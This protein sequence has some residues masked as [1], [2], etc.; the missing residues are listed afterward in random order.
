MRLL[1]TSLQR[2]GWIG[3]QTAAA[4]GEMIA[5]SARLEVAADKF[6]GIEPIIV[7]SDGTRPVVVIRTD[8]PSGDD[9]RAKRLSIADNQISHTDLDF[10]GDLLKEWGDE[11]KAIREMFGDAEW[12]EIVTETMSEE[13]AFGKLPDEDRA[14]FRQMTFTLHDTQAEQVFDALKLAKAQGAFVDSENEN[15]NGNALAR[16]CETYITEHGNG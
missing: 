16:I 12:R 11:D 2:D 7:E 14:P 6:Q 3:A 13:E 4:D 1:E 5:G 15:S 10:D 9:P 8:I